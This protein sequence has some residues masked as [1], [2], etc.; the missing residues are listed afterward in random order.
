MK[1]EMV[2][3]EVR[4]VRVERDNTDENGCPGMHVLVSACPMPHAS[5]VAMLCSRTVCRCWSSS[6]RG[7]LRVERTRGWKLTRRAVEM[8]GQGERG[9]I[10]G[11]VQGDQ[12]V[13]KEP[14]RRN[15]ATQPVVPALFC[16]QKAEKQ[17]SRGRGFQQGRG[18]RNCAA[19]GTQAWHRSFSISFPLL[20]CRA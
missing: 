15:G 4:R 10:W 9:D 14:L 6:C 8:A 11:G 18:A 5:P 7:P 3:A 1:E 12:G 16:N 20:A 17:C 13:G 2:D 19:D